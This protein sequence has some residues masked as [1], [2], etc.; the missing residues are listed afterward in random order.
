MCGTLSYYK[1]RNVY[2]QTVSQSLV[3]SA[4]LYMSAKFFKISHPQKFMPVKFFKAGHPQNFKCLQT[5]KDFFQM[6]QVIVHHML[7]FLKVKCCREVLGNPV[8]TMFLYLTF[9]YVYLAVLIQMSSQS[10]S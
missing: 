5:V 3:F 2:R 4:K 8:A 9:M 7:K 10:S 6:L 1:R